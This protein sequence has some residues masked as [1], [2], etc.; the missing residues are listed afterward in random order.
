VILKRFK[1]D[2]VVHTDFSLLIFI[3]VLNKSDHTS[4]YYFRYILSPINSNMDK[5]SF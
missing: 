3:H 5:L 1:D 4:D 2:D